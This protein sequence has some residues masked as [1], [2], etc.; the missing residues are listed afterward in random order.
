MRYFIGYKG[1]GD[2]EKY[3]QHLT[4]DL[5][6]RF[7]IADLSR[8][9]PPHFTLKYP[10]VVNNTANIEKSI[11]I[12]LEGKKSI[13]SVIDGFDR[14]DHETIFLS[15]APSHELSVF[16]KDCITEL[17]DLGDVEKF[18]ADTYRL[19]LSVARHLDVATFDLVWGYLND[20]PK[21]HFEFLFDNVTLFVEED[22]TWNAKKVFKMKTRDF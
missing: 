16:V 5:S 14:F 6:G 19:H 18:D 1:G 17:G 15:V 22:N 10:F 8:R 2:I 3:Y 13:P 11:E 21:P 4:A 20:L 7:G 9:V 12:F